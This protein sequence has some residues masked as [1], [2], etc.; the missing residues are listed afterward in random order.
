MTIASPASA[1]KHL[2]APLRVRTSPRELASIPEWI[3]CAWERLVIYPAAYWL[4]LW[5]TLRL[6]AAF[7]LVEAL[8]PT[9]TARV[10]REEIAAATG[11]Q[12]GRRALRLVARRLTERQRHLVYKRFIARH[13]LDAEWRFV[14][15]NAESAHAVLSGGKPVLLVGGHF[16]GTAATLMWAGALGE[17]ERLA[18]VSGPTPSWRLSPKVLRTRLRKG[19]ST[20]LNRRLFGDNAERRLPE[21]PDL[22]SGRAGVWKSA[23]K[24]TSVQDRVIELL[25]EPSGRAAIW[26]DAIWEK[27]EAYRRS[28]A[29]AEER[30]FAL[31]AARIAR[32]AQA[33]VIPFVAV[34]GPEPLTVRICSRSWSEASAT[35]QRTTNSP[36][37]GTESGSRSLRSGCGARSDLESP[38]RHTDRGASL[39]PS[40]AAS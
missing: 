20:G 2:S 24:R 26:P 27:P 11:G 21:M 29:G 16:T 1:L 35:T 28:F 38:P 14:E 9:V 10:A 12:R 33:T 31:G 30:G 18:G 4:P 39:W 25:S 40:A 32:L 34:H 19:A 22:W 37:A 3:R 15:G 7:G 8:L 17:R 23:P 6:T 13:G 5:V 36:S